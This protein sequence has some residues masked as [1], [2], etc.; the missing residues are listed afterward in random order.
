MIEPDG[1]ESG[2]SVNIL[3]LHQLENKTQYVENIEF[4]IHEIKKVNSDNYPSLY[5]AFHGRDRMLDKLVTM[6]E[7]ARDH[8]LKYEKDS[9]TEEKIY[10]TSVSIRQLMRGGGSPQ[11]W[12]GVIAKLTRLGLIQKYKPENNEIGTY[13]YFMQAEE[14]EKQ[15]RRRGMK[16]RENYYGISWY[17]F[18]LF[19][20]D[21]FETAEEKAKENKPSSR[22][23][24]ASMIDAYGQREADKAYYDKRWISKTTQQVRDRIDAAAYKRITESGY[25][26]VGQIMQAIHRRDGERIFNYYR[27][28]LTEKY[29][30]YYHKPTKAEKE[31]YCLKDNKYIFTQR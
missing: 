9:E 2:E 13:G 20:S 28:E 19:T 30:L 12:T 17:H 8:G 14:I 5:K 4:N 26:T 23:S 10:F 15:K 1:K 25:F 27:D 21:V 18:P 29:R 11:T 3:M 7:Y 6:L 16:S 22:T 24:K 31:K